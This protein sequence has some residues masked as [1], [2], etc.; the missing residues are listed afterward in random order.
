MNAYE[1]LLR[2][3]YIEGTTHLGNLTIVCDGE[4]TIAEDGG[5]LIKIMGVNSPCSARLC[6]ALRQL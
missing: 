2:V 3:K 5:S 1:R 6:D 4:S